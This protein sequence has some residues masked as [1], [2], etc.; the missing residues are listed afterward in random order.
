MSRRH[1]LSKTLLSL[2]RLC[3]SKASSGGSLCHLPLSSPSPSSSSCARSHL[4][5]FASGTTGGDDDGVRSNATSS[6]GRSD[7]GSTA[8]RFYKRATVEAEDESKTLWCIKLDGRKLKT[9][10]LRVLQLPNANLAH[11]I[12]MEWEYQS[13]NSIRPFTMPLMQLAT[14][15]R[16]QIE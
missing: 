15:G 4:R 6:V 1:A 3:C 2:Q 11:A 5:P 16:T 12:A 10:S 9:P 13:T 7:Q 14:T 8:P